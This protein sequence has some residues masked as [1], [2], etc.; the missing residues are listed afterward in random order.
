MNSYGTSDIVTNYWG[1]QLKRLHEE[2][3]IVINTLKMAKNHLRYVNRH[4]LLRHGDRIFPYFD[5]DNVK[6]VKD[7]IK[8]IAKTKMDNI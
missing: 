3:N 4:H 8:R 7:R 2:G 6:F 5:F 1:H